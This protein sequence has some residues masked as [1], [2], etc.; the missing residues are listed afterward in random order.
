MKGRNNRQWLFL[1]LPFIIFFLFRKA[2]V[3]T[4]FVFCIKIKS[5]L[6]AGSQT[7]FFF[8][9]FYRDIVYNIVWCLNVWENTK[10]YSRQIFYVYTKINPG[11]F[12]W[13]YRFL[14]Y[15]IYYN[16]EFNSK[17]NFVYLQIIYKTPTYQ[18]TSLVY[19]FSI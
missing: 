4:S 8:F 14:D 9:F 6:L 5:G 11:N 2:T 19:S 13:F 1:L 10:M 3:A 17:P 12:I 18:T 7:Q 15:V 16:H